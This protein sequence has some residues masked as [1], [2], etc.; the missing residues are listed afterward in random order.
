M[1]RRR[2]LR[3]AAALGAAALFMSACSGASHGTASAGAKSNFSQHELTTGTAHG[4]LS[5][6]RLVRRLPRALLRGPAQDR[7][8][9]RG[10]HP[11]QRLRAAAAHGRGLQPAP[12]HRA[13][14]EATGCAAPG[15][16]PESEGHLQ[17]RPSGDAGRRRLQP[18]AQPGP[19]R[20]QR[21]RGLLRVRLEHHR[22]RPR[23]GAPSPSPGPDV[24]LRRNNMGIL[25]G[26]DRRSPSRRRPGRTSAARRPA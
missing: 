8:L 22:D 18:D 17:R 10:D 7:G 26:A 13:V 4:Q 11:R 6:P 25:A 12:G 5:E 15:V 14:L 1:Y 9:P 24:H 21:L 20:R 3:T 16:Q 19:E 23:A 2:T